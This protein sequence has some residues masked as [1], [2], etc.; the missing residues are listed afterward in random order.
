MN[1]FSPKEPSERA[2]RQLLLY[3]QLVGGASVL[4]YALVFYQCHAPR[5]AFVE[6][7]YTVVILVSLVWGRVLPQHSRG[8]VWLHVVAV[9]VVCGTISFFQ[10]GVQAGQ[11]FISWGLISPVAALFL[12]G[13]WQAVV[14]GVLYGLLTIALATVPLT[15]MESVP[16][17]ATGPLLAGNIIGGMVLVLMAFGS[18]LRRLGYEDLRREQIHVEQTRANRLSSLGTLAGGIA[19]DFNNILMAFSGN[20]HLVRKD[21]PA[22]HP[23]HARLARAE[24]ALQ[25]ATGL[26]EQLLTFA[27]GGAPRRQTVRLEK[28]VEEAVSFVLHGT[29]ATARFEIE[30]GLPPVLGDL[31]QIAQVVQN[32]A[33]NGAQAMTRGGGEL[34]ISLRYFP[35]GDERLPL[36]LDV[37]RAFV[38]V[39]V[40]DHGRGISSDLLDRIFDPYFTTRDGGT[41][42]GLATAYSIARGHGGAIGVESTPGFGSTFTLYLP[43]SDAVLAPEPAPLKRASVGKRRLLIMDDEPAVL[44]VLGEMLSELGHESVATSEGSAAME[45]YARLLLEGKRYDAV[46]LDLTVKGGPGGVATAE[47][48]LREDPGAILVASS[49]YANDPVM[50]NCQ[51]FGFKAVLRKPYSLAMLEDT[52]VGVLGGPRSTGLDAEQANN[53]VRTGLT[54][55]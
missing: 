7:I 42:L 43:A 2:R 12:L 1:R 47:A 48:M 41:G 38:G 20:L 5:S 17:W 26:S 51:A 16:G 55:H 24:Q 25:E 54:L 14:M 46:I 30:A 4:L 31:T 37:Q 18:L 6:M 53:P 15:P 13:R 29:S 36:E 49:G 27:R 28:A 11:S 33:L 52:L 39:S 23:A 21:L 45:S 44:D 9:L 34:V 32:L 10:G 40:T 3:L 35:G 22:G 19:H 8:I 50:S